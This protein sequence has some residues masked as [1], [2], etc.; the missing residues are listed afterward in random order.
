M[1][2]T[3]GFYNSLAGDRTYNATQMG[4]MFDG[5]VT[6]G[7]YQ[8]YGSAFALLATTGLSFT[9]GSGRAWFNHT[10]TLN[11]SLLTLTCPAA[12]PTLPRY[13]AVIL[14]VDTSD[15]VRA[16]TIKIISGVAASS[17]VKPS[18]TNSGNVHQYALGYI[19]RGGGS[20]SITQGNITTAVG[21]IETPFASSSLFGN[22]SIYSMFDSAGAYKMHR[23]TFRGK[24]L[25]GK[26]TTG[27]KAAI[28]AGTF[29]DLWLGDYWVI[30]GITYR[31][32]DIDYWYLTGQT[33]CTK[34]HVVVMPDQ[35]MYNAVMNS[36]ATAANGYG[37]S[38]MRSSKLNAAKSSINSAFP[39]A[40]VSHT[41]FFTTSIGSDDVVSQAWYPAT[42][43]IPSA[44]ML[45]GSTYYGYE[46]HVV[47]TS[48][49]SLFAVDRTFMVP[50]TS[51]GTWLNNCA[52]TTQFAYVTS[53]SS[54][55]YL[56]A[57]TNSGVRPVFAVGV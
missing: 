28:Q 46:R 32:V 39:S 25:G 33:P 14:E 42:V 10:W 11:D 55:Y 38:D 15:A 8:A 37:R 4:S 56:D 13:D 36:T 27:Q 35:T 22:M 6:D 40:V 2:V 26:L 19:Y 16:N 9:V 12:D 34:H 20:S 47:S 7:V 31:I 41:E 44:V 51:V 23:T 18:L 52:S 57:N 1:A 53:E 45:F 48:Q 43:E 50:S 21:T 54:A 29:D 49:L 5:V 24:N 3:G 17:P 30:G